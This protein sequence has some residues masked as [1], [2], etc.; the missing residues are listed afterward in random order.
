MTPPTL[1][2]VGTDFASGASL[3]PPAASHYL[4]SEQHAR[5]RLDQISGLG[6]GWDGE[7]AE[8]IDGLAVSF[9][10]SVIQQAL[11]AGLPDLEIFPVPDGGVQLEW[12]AGPVELEL[13]IEPGARAVI[14]ACDDERA[15][16]Q[17]D[18]ELPRDESRFAL[19]LARLN[20]YG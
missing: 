19:A 12:R 3:A 14:F 1:D 15:G 2:H 8:P 9:A 13:E 11:R 20:A 6:A 5:E 7:H 18:G 4:E 16:Q 17:I 10:W